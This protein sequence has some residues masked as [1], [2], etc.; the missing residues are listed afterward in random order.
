MIPD[1]FGF[2][3]PALGKLIS[4]VAKLSGV[5]RR[6]LASMGRKARAAKK[7]TIRRLVREANAEQRR[8][9]SEMDPSE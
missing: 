5:Q 8:L 2:E 9:L 7:T 4:H 6:E 1:L 3:R